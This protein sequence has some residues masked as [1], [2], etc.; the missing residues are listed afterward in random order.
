MSY[1][2]GERWDR[3]RFEREAGRRAPVLER[4]YDEHDYY[5]RPGLREERDIHEED[6]YRRPYAPSPASKAGRGD[7]ERVFFEEREEYGAPV[8]YRPRRESVRYYDDRETVR[9]G[10]MVPFREREDD[11]EIDIKYTRESKPS[12]RPQ[13]I[14]RQ[15]SLDTF[16]RKPFP[17]YGDRI[18]E[19]VVIPR[20]PRRRSPPR[21]VE[22]DYDEISV[23][24]PEYGDEEY[25]PY[26]EREVETLR[27]RYPEP[28]RR[29]E[30]IEER[31]EIVEEFPKRGKTKMP[32]RL[33][34]IQAIIHLGYP[35]E[36][37]G[38]TIIIQK[39]LGKEH[40]D[41]VIQISREYNEAP[42]PPQEGS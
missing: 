32:R 26:R 7:R 40:I 2:P 9:G 21:Y 25:R 22:R 12:R 36:E 15:S 42:P 11:R 39:A 4:D 33:V 24:G 18:R 28:P 8:P 5:S 38:E 19:E 14:R 30:I 10:D 17:R 6:I 1:G 13:F 41:E 37:E 27:R 29:E 23:A 3:D 34:N 20:P 31:E 16:D 35:Y